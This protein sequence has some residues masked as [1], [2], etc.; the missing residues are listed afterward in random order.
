MTPWVSTKN[1]TIKQTDSLVSQCFIVIIS[2][3]AR[4]THK[5]TP[6]SV[7]YESVMFE[8]PPGILTISPSVQHLTGTLQNPLQVPNKILGT[9]K[10]KTSGLGYKHYDR[11]WKRISCK[12][13]ARW[14]HLSRLKASAF[15]CLKKKYFLRN[16]TTFTRIGNTI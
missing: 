3:M 14:Q 8:I 16:A 12:Q 15:F 6:E 5:L 11:Q 2:P 7:Q 4:Q 9:P 1:I 10:N 13:N